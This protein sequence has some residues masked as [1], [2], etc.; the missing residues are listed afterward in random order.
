MK[1]LI[2][3]ILIGSSLVVSACNMTPLQQSAVQT[4]LQIGLRVAVAKIAE[5]NPGI[6]PYLQIVGQS[7]KDPA[8]STEPEALEKYLSDIIDSNVRDAN[9]N[10]ALHDL[11]EMI[12]EFYAQVYDRH[13]GEMTDS[14]YMEIISAFGDAIYSGT[15]RTVAG[16]VYKLATN[17]TIIIIE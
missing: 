13:S 4:V 14:V 1:K 6:A 11:A 16:P 7:L 3:S 17:E 12:N 8:Q 9:Y 10:Q 2:I 15:M 5:A